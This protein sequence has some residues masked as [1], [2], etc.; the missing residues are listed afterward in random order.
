MNK[1]KLYLWHKRLGLSFGFI[2]FI[3]GLSGTVITYRDELLP[4]VYSDI[5]LVTPTSMR[6]PVQ[7]VI[8]S[9]RNHLGEASFT[10]LYTS[11]RED[12]ATMLFTKPQGAIL[13]H[14]LAIDP[15]TAK[16]TGEMPLIKNIF[17]IMLYL[18]ANLLLGKSGSIIVGLMGLLLSFF[19]ITGIMIFWGKN[20]KMKLKAL[21]RSGIR[22]IHR[23]L[24][25]FLGLALLFSGITGFILAFDL[26]GQKK[27][28]DMIKTAQCNLNDQLQALN[29]LTKVQLKNIVSIHFCSPKNGL[30]KISSGLDERSGHHGYT[31]VIIDPATKNIVQ[32]FDT[33]KDPPRW[34]VNA[35]TIYPLHTGSYFG[36]AGRIITLLTGLALSGLYI[37]GL[38][39][40]LRSRKRIQITM[41]N[42][43]LDR[44]IPRQDLV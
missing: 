24:G 9:A 30:I 8:K 27:P 38:I 33:R 15:Y 18:H 3:L 19:F 21:P 41:A 39:I 10:H 16:V 37:T 22:G 42:I 2:L 28:E 29:I 32:S 35:L 11:E 25:I 20:W 6:L 40:S 34:S 13:P 44:Q 26:M 5:M 1:K 12:T 17:G 43:G 14:L 4:K 7:E 31:K 36:P 23:S